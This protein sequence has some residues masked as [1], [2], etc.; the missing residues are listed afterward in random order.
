LPQVKAVNE[1]Y[2]LAQRWVST[3]HVELN[4]Y[5]RTCNVIQPL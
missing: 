5:R 3:N 4:S 1:W 2:M